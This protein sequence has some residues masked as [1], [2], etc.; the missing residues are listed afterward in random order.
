MN[1]ISRRV[2]Y[3]GDELGRVCDSV[4][5][6]LC[7]NR[8]IRDEWQKKHLEW[9][10]THFIDGPQAQPENAGV[11]K[12]DFTITDSGDYWLAVFSGRLDISIS[13]DIEKKLNDAIQK[14]PKPLIVN[15]SDVQYMSSSGLRILLTIHSKLRKHGHSVL[16]GGASDMV[17]KLFL[18][19]EVFQMF[20]VL[21]SVDDAVEH[22]AG[23]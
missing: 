13:S 12:L 23:M 20:P 11:D 19:T 18:V 8:Q 22:L 4:E 5:D 10:R 9:K 1:E 15:F 21:N 14:S 2:F 16:V 17:K 3:Y 6:E 7:M